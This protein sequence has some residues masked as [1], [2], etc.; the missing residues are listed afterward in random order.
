MSRKKKT[1][2]VLDI[3]TD[4]F[5]YGRPPKPFILGFYDGDTYE[6]FSGAD[7]VAQCV[8]WLADQ[9]TDY[10][11]YAHNGGKF[12][13]FFFLEHFDPVLKIINGRIAKAT[14]DRHEFRDSYMILPL[15]LAAH[16]KDDF[17]Y[18]ILEADQ[19]DK[20]E[21]RKK[22]QLYLRHD[23]EYLFDWVSKFTDRFGRKLT[24]ASAAF[25]QLKKTGYEIPQG[26]P[27]FDET[28]RPYYFGGRVEAIEPG[29]HI[30]EF[31]YYDI[32]SAYPY[33][34]QYQHPLGFEYERLTHL[35]KKPPYFATV[36]ARSLGALPYRAQ[37]GSL[38]FPRDGE[39][40][41]YHA[42][43]WE[44]EAGIDTNTLEIVT[45][46]QCLK[47]KFTRNFTDYVDKFFK[48]KSDA[49]KAGDKDTEIFAK[50]MLNSAYGK[51]GMD[52]SKFK[53]YCLCEY[54]TL[55]PHPDTG[56][57][58]TTERQIEETLKP[59]GPWSKTSQEQG[60]AIYER[61]APGDSYYNVATASS[62]TG[63][64]RA[65]IWRSICASERPIYCDTDSLMCEKFN[66]PI[67]DAL[68]EW[69]LEDPLSEISIGGKKM[70]AV[71]IDC[72]RLTLDEI[73]ARNTAH[74]EKTGKEME[75]RDWWKTASKGA[76][77]D[78]L[79]IIEVAKGNRVTWRKDA[80][81]FSL[82]YGARFIQRNIE[83]T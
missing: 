15:P 11:I 12:D 59:A 30:G 41:E 6:E 56:L 42:T 61:D 33:A 71:R 39:L 25:D 40:R 63:F 57:E 43:G 23:C 8:A 32:N 51:F 10:L 19:R 60:Y 52:P 82:R 20:P 34:M 45:V 7:C 4:P 36:L 80:P 22:I 29:S 24:L 21:N 64:V 83:R 73:F 9:P 69:K 68:G 13:Y 28:F 77:L 27:Y 47:P 31:E 75:E 37:D 70:Y 38:S 44:I 26:N 58:P 74:I 18:R 2:A 35:P 79:Q 76:R 49:K 66:G 81:S 1:L 3:E 17:D 65:H 50:L 53:E 54:G 48:E 14:I 62:I 55:P 16:K 67:G 72:H 46:L 78:Y 5:K